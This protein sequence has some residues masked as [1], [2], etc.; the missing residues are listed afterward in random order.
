VP[1][2]HGSISSMTVAS[3]PPAASEPVG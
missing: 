3:V 2:M 1:G